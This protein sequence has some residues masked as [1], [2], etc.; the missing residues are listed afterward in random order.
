MPPHEVYIEPFL[1]TGVILRAKRPAKVT[2]G[3][4]RDIPTFTAFKLRFPE[5]A[6]TARIQY[7]DGITFLATYDFTGRELVYCDPPYLLSTRGGRRYYD[8]ELS[9]D[10]HFDLLTAVR[11]LPC[12]VILS[13][14]W[15]PLYAEQLKGWRTRTFHTVDRAGNVKSEWLWM[16]F[17]E[18][19][20]LH[21]PRFLGANFRERERINRKKKRWVNRLMKMAALERFA[22]FEAISEAKALYESKNNSVSSDIPGTQFV[23]PGADVSTRLGTA[24]NGRSL[25]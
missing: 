4:E 14:Y 9:E 23:R 7:G 19:F 15:P 18:P 2:I 6:K 8:H 21:D 16:N 13:G 17:P 10:D 1:G 5:I 22:I 24:G 12:P 25:R 3:I 20:A 11:R